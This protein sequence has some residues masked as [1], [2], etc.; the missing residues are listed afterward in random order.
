ME[1]VRDGFAAVGRNIDSGVRR[2]SGS[3]AS[4]GPLSGGSSTNL[5]AADEDIELPI[6][7]ATT[8]LSDG[9]EYAIRSV[10]TW[11]LFRSCDKEL[12]SRIYIFRL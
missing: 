8:A 6:L 1:S 7:E 10:L 9:C 4:V 12:C 3:L 5:A 2:A 11:C